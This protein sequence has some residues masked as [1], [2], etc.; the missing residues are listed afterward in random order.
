MIY[1]GKTFYD[2]FPR[3]ATAII[4]NALPG[5]TR[6]TAAAAHGFS[7]SIRGCVQTATGIR[8]WGRRETTRALSLTTDRRGLPPR[9]RRQTCTVATWRTEISVGFRC[10]R[11]GY[12]VRARYVK[13]VSKRISRVPDNSPCPEVAG[14]TRS[15]RPTIAGPKNALLAR[16]RGRR[17]N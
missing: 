11:S 10:T 4:N 13:T 3:A 7:G 16:G 8:R 14:K 15:V 1:E 5:R 6:E 12:G 2:P 17:P 9:C